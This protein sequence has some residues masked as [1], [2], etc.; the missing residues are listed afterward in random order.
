MDSAT[1]V[2]FPH[3]S[4]GAKKRGHTRKTFLK[5]HPLGCASSYELPTRPPDRCGCCECG[6]SLSPPIMLDLFR[7]CAGQ[8]PGNCATPDRKKW[9]QPSMSAKNPGNPKTAAA[10][11]RPR[12]DRVQDARGERARDVLDC[13]LRPSMA[14]VRW[15]TYH[16]GGD[17]RHAVLVKIGRYW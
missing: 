14:H 16:G 8:F 17:S 11:P 4:L 9:R 12:S 15:P 7:S 3:G 2:P 13:E 1:H 10:G 6:A 5:R